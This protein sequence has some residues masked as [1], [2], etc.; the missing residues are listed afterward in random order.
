MDL[1]SK[2][3]AVSMPFRS[4]VTVATSR[5]VWFDTGVVKL[6]AELLNQT[7]ASLAPDFRAAASK[8]FVA[9]APKVVV[10]EAAQVGV[11]KRAGV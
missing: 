1:M 5:V 3:F 6:G 7:A 4:I 2:I 8:Y 10:T 11:S 9:G